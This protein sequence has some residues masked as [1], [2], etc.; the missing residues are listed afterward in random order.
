MASDTPLSGTRFRLYRRAGG[1]AVFVCLATTLSMTKSK[2]FDDATMPDCDDPT[3]IPTRKSV[4]KSRGWS[5]NFAGAFV[6]KHR[7]Q[8]EA[9]YDSDT[10]VEY[11]IRVDPADNDGA[12]SWIGDLHIETFEVGKSDNGRANITVQCRG[13]GELPW[14][15]A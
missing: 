9:D 15:D 3:K 2:E 12:G 13:E 8:V 4:V 6:A 14:T 7:A 1:P 10:P 5:L 11:E